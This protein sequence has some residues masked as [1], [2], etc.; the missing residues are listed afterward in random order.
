MFIFYF[1]YSIIAINLFW[2][3]NNLNLI[4]IQSLK[5]WLYFIVPS[6]FIIFLV[7]NF[8]LRNKFF[9]KFC[10]ILKPFL[11]FDSPFSYTIFVNCALSG[12]PTTTKLIQENFN[13]SNISF[14]DYNILLCICKFTNP[15]FII[16]FLSLR[17]YLL[18]L[19]SLF[20][21]GI[22]ITRFNFPYPHKFD[23]GKSS[24]QYTT[25]DLYSSINNA[26]SILLLI[27]G[28]ITFYNI[29]CASINSLLNYKIIN[30]FTLF[31]E[32]SNGISILSKSS[33]YFL[34]F[35]LLAS[36]GICIITQSYFTLDKKNIS[37]SRYIK[38]HLI[39]LLCSFTIFSII[40]SFSYIA[41]SALPL[42]SFFINLSS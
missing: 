19:L 14:R 30:Q 25:S 15:L 42:E 16:S 34:V 9:Y 11:K 35:L 17:F 10:L 5:T 33:N 21:T 39:F 23:F 13:N 29:V 22:I 1:I 20:L 27:A 8:L 38:L 7:S 26:I 2:N 12:N 40:Y 4:I 18:Y 6:F 36:Q 32:L 41:N 24:L 31:I 28:T 37:L 3:Y